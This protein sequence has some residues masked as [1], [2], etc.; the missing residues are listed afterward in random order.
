ML[1]GGWVVGIIVETLGLN[2]ATV[3]R[4]ARVICRPG[5]GRYLAHLCQ[6]VNAI[7]YTDCKALQAWLLRTY[8]VA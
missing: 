4:Y 7:F 2:K 8:R 5:P 1:D 3:Y 6:E